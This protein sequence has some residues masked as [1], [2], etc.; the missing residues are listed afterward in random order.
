MSIS[1]LLCKKRVCF[2]LCNKHVFRVK[3]ISKKLGIFSRMFVCLF[4]AI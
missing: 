3:N 2:L 4:V 1:V